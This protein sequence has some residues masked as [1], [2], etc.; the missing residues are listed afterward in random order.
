MDRLEIAMGTTGEP[1]GAGDQRFHDCLVAD[2]GDVLLELRAFG[3]HAQLQERPCPIVE[4]NDDIAIV[5]DVVS[6][7]GTLTGLM[8][9]L[10]QDIGGSVVAT[11]VVFTEGDP[12]DDVIALGHLPLYPAET[13]R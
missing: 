2:S 12:R 9:L 11:L 13:G 7:G 5:D 10:E 4:I 1:V 3:E 8:E 6:T